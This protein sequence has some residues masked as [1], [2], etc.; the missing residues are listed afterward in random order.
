M[1]G[2]YDSSVIPAC[3]KSPKKE[4]LDFFLGMNGGQYD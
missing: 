3:G 1:W 2:K 4:M